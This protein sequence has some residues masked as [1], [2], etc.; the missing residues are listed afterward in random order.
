MKEVLSNPKKYKL[1]TPIT[2]IVLRDSD[3]IT[4]SDSCL[5]AKDVKLD[6][7]T[8]WWHAK[9]PESIK[10]LTLKRLK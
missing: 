1:E 2:R 10:S 3:F 5:E 7:L 4:V 9:Y 8:F 6:I